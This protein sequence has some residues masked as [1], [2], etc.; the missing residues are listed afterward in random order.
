MSTTL[1]LLLADQRP[2]PT[3]R[4]VKQYLSFKGKNFSFPDRIQVCGRLNVRRASVKVEISTT[5]KEY[6]A[7]R[8]RTRLQKLRP[9]SVV[10]EP[11][12]QNTGTF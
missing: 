10:R 12:L 5:T 9:E 3:L 8:H 4:Y 6:S 1:L 7:S 2:L 11:I